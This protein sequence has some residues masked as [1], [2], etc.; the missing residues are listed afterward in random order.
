MIDPITV[1]KETD[2]VELPA[3]SAPAIP[4]S[5]GPVV[6]QPAPTAAADGSGPSTAGPSTTVGTPAAIAV[7]VTGLVDKTSLAAQATATAPGAPA[8]FPAGPVN[9]YQYDELVFT[10][11]T[12]PFL[13][14]LQAHPPTPL[15]VQP[16]VKGRLEFTLGME[17]EEGERIDEGRRE[18]VR[19]TDA[20]R[21][22]LI[23]SEREVARLRQEVGG[24]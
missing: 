24:F 21:K 11:P 19:E 3:S 14:I 2:T 1:D 8:A 16:R 22:R 6:P 12:A 23:D 20:W 13:A 15:P 10:N 4:A 5:A 18:V 7:D 17:R 9:A